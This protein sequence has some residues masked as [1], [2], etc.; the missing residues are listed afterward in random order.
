MQTDLSEAQGRN[1]EP[2]PRTGGGLFAFSL[3]FICGFLK[4]IKPHKKEIPII[5]MG[6]FVL[7]LRSAVNAV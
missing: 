6:I 5:T 3:H 1:N 2:P 4:C 7:P